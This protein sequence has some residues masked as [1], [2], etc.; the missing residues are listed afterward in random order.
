MGV[1]T[2]ILDVLLEGLTKVPAS[3]GEAL[4]AGMKAIFIDA[5]GNIS[6]F[7]YVIL[8]FGG[9]ALALGLCKLVFNIIRSKIG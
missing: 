4:N 8:A 3:I 2:Q 5:E 1:V 6:T 7:A 9:I